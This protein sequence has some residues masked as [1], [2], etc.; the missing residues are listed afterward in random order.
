MDRVLRFKIGDRLV[1]TGEEQ[2][3]A[4]KGAEAIVIQTCLITDEYVEVEW[5]ESSLASI[6]RNG[7]YFP[8]YFKLVKSISFLDI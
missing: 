1:Y 3:A 5:I 8:S 6:Q 4:K 7:G 2:L